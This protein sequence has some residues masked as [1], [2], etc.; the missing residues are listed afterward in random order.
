[1]AARDYYS[2][3]DVSPSATVA[4][5][6]KA[7]WRKAALCHPDRG[8]SHEAMLQIAE[9]WK[10]LSDSHKRSRYDQ[11]LTH[12]PESWRNRRFTTNSK[13]NRNRG[14][15]RSTETA[16]KFEA[17]YRQ[18]LYTFNQDLYGGDGEDK[19]TVPPT[20]ND[21]TS[22][23]SSTRKTLVRQLISSLLLFIVMLSMVLLSR[24]HSPVGRYVPL[25]L[26]DGYPVLF[27]DTATGT[28]YSVDRLGRQQQRGML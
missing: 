27:M 26:K 7:Y 22:H 11:L 13:T 23:V 3:L 19:N 12:R 24:N 16:A 18:A 9:A 10:I 17:I 28:V 25:E 5:I 21:S 2:L 15:V 20:T 4:D 8:G 14:T 6:H 1:M